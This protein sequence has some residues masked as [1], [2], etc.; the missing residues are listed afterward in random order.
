MNEWNKINLDEYEYDRLHFLAGIIDSKDNLKYIHDNVNFLNNLDE[1]IKRNLNPSN[2]NIYEKYVSNEYE[3]NLKNIEFFQIIRHFSHKYQNLY[4]RKSK[5]LYEDLFFVYLP[6]SRYIYKESM[7]DFR[8][9]SI[10]LGIQAHQGCGKTTFCEII[11]FLTKNIYELNINSLSIDD[12]YLS[13]EELKKLR[14]EDPRFKFRGPPG[15]HDVN[16]GQEILE[17]VKNRK[18]L[19]DIPRYDKS[20]N[21]GLGDRAKECIKIYRPL[22]VLIFEGWFLG[23][24]PVDEDILE[25]YCTNNQSTLEFQKLINNNLHNYTPLWNQVN[26]WIIMKPIKYEFSKKWRHDAEKNNIQKMK[27]KTLQEFINYFW[28]TVPPYI[29]FPR[30]EKNKNPILT[31]V[32]D[33]DRNFYL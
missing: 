2:N 16:L 20:A 24:E 18:I 21:K 11:S 15:T 10:I 25:K 8:N 6:L 31:L 30:I 7:T 23:S 32:I 1:K 29:Y 26:Y 9:S 27:Y 19:Y 3:R 33:I 28:N 14:K 17:N 22:D 5:K 12:I 4:Y 13:Y